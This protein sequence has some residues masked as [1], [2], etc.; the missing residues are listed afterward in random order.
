M[1]LIIT[2]YYEI[3][4]QCSTCVF[5]I[6]ASPRDW[7]DGRCVNASTLKE[8]IPRKD[9][10]LYVSDRDVCNHFKHCSEAKKL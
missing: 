2:Q 1:K 7:L 8:W 5:F 10:D 9:K 6:A 3:R 4:R